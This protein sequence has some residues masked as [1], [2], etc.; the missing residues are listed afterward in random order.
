LENH[1]MERCLQY[2]EDATRMAISL[3]AE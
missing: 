1:L 2:A 3:I